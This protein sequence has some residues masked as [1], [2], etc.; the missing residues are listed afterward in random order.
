MFRSQYAKPEDM[1]YMSQAPP[2][3]VDQYL[4]P[5]SLQ[6]RPKFTSDFDIPI[7]DQS[8]NIR[9]SLPL[10]NYPRVNQQVPNNGKGFQGMPPAAGMLSPNQSDPRLASNYGSFYVGAIPP[11]N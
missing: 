11:N 1:T 10:E 9:F 4:L 3:L 5:P 6:A 7:Y 8:G 2:A